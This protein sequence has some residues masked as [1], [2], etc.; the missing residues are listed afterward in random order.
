V[1]AMGRVNWYGL[2]AVLVLAVVR[3]DTTV[4]AAIVAMCLVG[5]VPRHSAGRCR[6]KKF[7][8]RTVR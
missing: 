5:A 6:S 1:T 7:S 2:V 8:V 3:F 4:I